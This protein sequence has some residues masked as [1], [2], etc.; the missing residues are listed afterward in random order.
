MK[1]KPSDSRIFKG[2]KWDGSSLEG[3]KILILSEQGFGDTINFIRFFP[4]IKEKKGYIILECKKE[5]RKLF[6]DSFKIDEVVEKKGDFAPNVNFDFYIHLMSLPRI[7]GTNLSNIPN[8]FPYLFADKELA[9]KFKSQF[10]KDHFNVGVVWA[11]NPEQVNDK[12]RS[13]KFE[14]FKILKDI[15]KVKLYS[16]Q[17][18]EAAKE[19]DNWAV[20]L[21]DQINCF[22]DTA[23]IID[24][25]DLIITVDTSVAHLAGAMG[26]RVWILLAFSSDWRW[27]LDRRD[28]PW[29]PSA[30]LFRQPKLGD[31]D[32]VFDEV[33]KELISL[34]H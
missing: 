16:L 23:A 10:D 21:S 24:N 30:K 19:L 9:K 28:S 26:K 17:K 25:L 22:A 27:L 1:E 18:G 3:K 33:R 7:F 29:Y 14:K 32:S 11:G 13:T 20:D 2:T 31:W 34:V 5:L 6:E 8:R 12:K 4:L 15:S